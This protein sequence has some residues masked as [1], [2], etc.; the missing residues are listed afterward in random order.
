MSFNKYHPKIKAFKDDLYYDL[1]E[2]FPSNIASLFFIGRHKRR[3]EGDVLHFYRER[4][5]NIDNV[6][7]PKQIHSNLVK[8]AS[9]GVVCDSIHTKS[10]N[11][12]IGVSVADC[13]P[14]G[15]SV[16]NGSEIF[17]IHSGYK[18]T[19]LK[20]VTNV[21]RIIDTSFV[22]SVYIGVSIKGCCYKINDERI[23]EFEK[24]FPNS[25]FI[26]RERSSVDLSMLNYYLLVQNGVKEE[27]IFVDTRCSFCGDEN[28]ASFRRDLHNSGRMTLTMV[29]L[30]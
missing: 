16:R 17:V 30:K 14:I 8:E 29:M 2:I 12:A 18:G 1:S 11:I 15:I 19:L 9:S 13:V 21:C 26:Y 27:K 7:F 5:F 20:I 28:Y 25:P 24:V 23:L 3:N 22:D 10:K 4:G 6:F